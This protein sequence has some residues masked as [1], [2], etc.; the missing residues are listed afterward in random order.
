MPQASEANGR[1]ERAEGRLGS[2]EYRAAK[3]FSMRGA[4]YEVGDRVD[5]SELP[6]VKISQLLDQ[7]YIRPA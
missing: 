3:A 6:E 4:D 5:M 1:G 7:R 2:R